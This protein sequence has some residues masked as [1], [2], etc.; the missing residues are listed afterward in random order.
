M[1]LSSVNEKLFGDEARHAEAVPRHGRPL[2]AGERDRDLMAGS[3]DLIYLFGIAGHPAPSP[4]LGMLADAGW[5]V[6]VPEVRGFDGRSDSSCPTTI[7]A[8]SPCSGMRSARVWRC[9]SLRWWGHRSAGCL[10]GRPRR[11]TARGR[12]PRPARTVRH[13]RRGEPGPRPLLG[14][15]T[16]SHDPP[17][18]KGVPEPYVDRFGELGP[19]NGPIARYLSDVA[20]ASLWPL[21]D[22]GQANRLHRI[23]CPSLSLWGEQDE[24]LPV[25][26]AS[27]AGRRRGFRRDRRRR[28]APPEW[29][30]PDEVGARLVEFLH[31]WVV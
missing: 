29:D 3:H 10:R 28:R 31:D 2:V 26:R 22:R 18:A 25:E 23:K 1:G 9:A 12:R 5:N 21:G 15:H 17:L 7:S 20:T 16:G 27:R 24:L 19:D 8:G 4:V 30:T 6:I 14:A 13:L 11:A